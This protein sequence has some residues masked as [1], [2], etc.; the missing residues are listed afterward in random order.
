MTYVL[1]FKLR[2]KIKKKIPYKILVLSQRVKRLFLSNYFRLRGFQILNSYSQQLEDIYL[3][4]ELSPP[5]RFLKDMYLV[6]VGA[7]D[8]I[9]Y[10]NTLMLENKFQLKTILIEPEP[11]NYKKILKNRPN[12]TCLNY[13]I[14][15]NEEL[16]KFMCGGAVGGISSKMSKEH[17]ISFSSRFVKEIEILALPLSKVLIENEVKEIYLLSIDCEGGDLDVLK[18]INFKEFFI[19][20]ILIEISHNKTEIEQLITAN[21]FY[22]HR[23][24]FGNQIWVN[25]HSKLDSKAVKPSI[26]I[27]WKTHSLQSRF[28]KKSEEICSNFKQ[29]NILF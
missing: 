22:L 17:K 6:E 4:N 11:K 29:K 27:A 16:V 21:D 23:N 18:S 1:G 8:G 26:P 5:K 7:L 10:S 9:R 20:I 24:L 3:F 15:R 12:S 25:N 2:N 28:K 13:A 14:S 19:H